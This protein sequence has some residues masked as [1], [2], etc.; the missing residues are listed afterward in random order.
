MHALLLALTLSLPAAAGA[1][2]GEPL[3]EGKQRQDAVYARVGETVITMEEFE[4]AFRLGVRQRF[5]HGRIPQERLTAYREEVGQRL[6]DRVLM[7]Q[8]ARRRGITPDDAWVAERLEGYLARY[9]GS[10]AW[11]GDEDALARG[12]Q[13]M[14]EEQSLLARLEEQV[15]ATAEP[16][17]AEV[18]DYY[19]RHPELFTTP[20]A[21]R[22]AMIL[23]KVAPS[24]P[25]SVWQAAMDEARRLKE[26]LERGAEFAN[27]ARIHSADASAARGGDLGWQHQGMLAPAAEAVLQALSP[28]EVSEPVTLLEGVALFQL[29]ERRPARLNPYEQVSE[30]ARALLQRERSQQAWEAFLARLRSEGDVVIV[31]TGD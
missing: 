9:R 25:A 7:L 30:R 5:Y 20:P 10:R 13:Q 24:S 18:R 2:A 11:R 22:A 1:A 26:R 17:D 29:Q 4:A 21:Y 23:L 19:R 28:G 12:L 14:L 6:I 31:A 8:E 27:L 3:Q 16:S 15:R